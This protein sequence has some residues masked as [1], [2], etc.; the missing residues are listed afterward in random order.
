MSNKKP[1]VFSGGP[2]N[3]SAQQLIQKLAAQLK[4][5]HESNESALSLLKQAQGYKSKA[6][7]LEALNKKLRDEIAELKR[8]QNATYQEQIDSIEKECESEKLQLQGELGEIKRQLLHSDDSESYIAK[9]ESLRH[10]YQEKLKRVGEEK[11]ELERQLEECRDG[12]GSVRIKE[13]EEQ[14][15][16]MTKELEDSEVV[17]ALAA[18][19]D[20]LWSVIL[21]LRPFILAQEG[22]V[23]QALT[24]LQF[25]DFLSEVIAPQISGCEDFLAQYLQQLNS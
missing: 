3:A 2:E 13:L 10:T 8:E 4:Q 20:C 21:S 6:T 23:D 16:I 22:A 7:T 17:Q 18:K 24:E 14:V 19:T 5:L 25:R 1:I 9:V 12:T 15:N 11:Q